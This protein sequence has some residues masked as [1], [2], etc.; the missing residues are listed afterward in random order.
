MN[1]VEQILSRGEA[2]APAV[3]TQ[4]SICTYG[5]LRQRVNYIAA[6]LLKRGHSKGARI[7][8]FAENSAFFVAVYLG[9][10][11]AGLVAVPLPT[12]LGAESLA[13]MALVSGMS[14]VLAST[15]LAKRARDWAGLAGIPALSETELGTPAPDGAKSLPEIE[16]RQD[17]ASLMF[18]S[19]STGSPKAVMI[20][21]RN[22]ECNAQDIIGYMGLSAADRV[23]VVLPF[24]YCFG[25]SLLHTHLMTGAALV[26]N[27]AFK[28]FPEQVLEEMRGQNC[29]G[30]AGVPSTYQILLRKTRFPTLTFPGLRWFQQAGGKLPDACIRE[31]RSSFPHVRFFLMYGQTEGTSRLSYLPPERL[32]EKFGSI[33][34]GLSS[35]R[36]EVLKGDGAPVVPGSGEIGEIVASGENIGQ[37]YWNDPVETA[38]FF[39]NGKL[40]TGDLARVDDDGFIFFVERT[41]DM[42]KVGGNRVSSREVEGVIAEIQDVVE[43]AVIGV[44]HD[45]LGEAI[46]AF[47][48]PRRNSG[49]RPDAILTHCRNRLPAFKVPHEINFLEAMPYNSAGKILKPKLREM[50][51]A[52]TIE[53]PMPVLANVAGASALIEAR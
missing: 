3:L 48:V 26:L 31:L 6:W 28:L 53:E 1:V 45:L 42:I 46:K 23:M 10:I 43:V 20:T 17:L 4:N 35:T 7:G 21:H 36:L 25:L 29:T 11:R 15:R 24:F 52:P 12:E 33:G 13:K 19:G 30:L 9:I 32:Q 5:E 16:P 41:R 44:A 38:V 51:K 50:A 14:E 8:I 39:K 47:V 37:G 27:N 2:A 40:H 49:L 18:T 34:K 22:I